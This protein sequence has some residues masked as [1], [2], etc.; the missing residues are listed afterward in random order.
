MPSVTYDE[1]NE[2]KV[3]GDASGLVGSDGVPELAGT[4]GLALRVRLDGLDGRTTVVALEVTVGSLV[5]E[6]VVVGLVVG[7]FVAGGN[8]LLSKRRILGE[9]RSLG[10]RGAGRHDDGNGE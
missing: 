1:A 9:L 4:T 10:G 8:M 7:A 3:K 5:T 2:G 6:F